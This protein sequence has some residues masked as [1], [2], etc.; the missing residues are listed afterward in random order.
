MNNTLVSIFSHNDRTVILARY[1]FEQLGFTNFLILDDS[2]GFDEKYRQ[3]VQQ[4]LASKCSYFIRSDGDCLVFREIVRCL[5]TFKKD[6]TRWWYETYYFDYF[7]NRFRGGTPHVMKRDLLEY[8]NKHQLIT[9]GKKPETMIWE[10]IP[11]AN[12][13][14]VGYFTNLHDFE[15]YPSKAFQTYRNRLSRGSSQRLYDPEH[16]AS[17]P[18]DYKVAMDL[19]EK[20][21]KSSTINY[22]NEDISY[23]DVNFTPIL[24]E[25]IPSLYSKYKDLYETKLKTF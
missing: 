1:C 23:L 14:T 3:F 21:G 8:I 19:A 16:L 10:T 6:P 20:S 9:N 4:G 11:N 15:Q 24:P 13:E 17:L 5:E 12:R 2:S 22:T 7:M 25:E 18:A